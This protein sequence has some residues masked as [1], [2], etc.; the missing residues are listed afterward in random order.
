MK[1][2]NKTKSRNIKD[3]IKQ[4]P[5]IEVGGLSDDG[6]AFSLHRVM[7]VPIGEKVAW[8]RLECQLKSTVMA[9]PKE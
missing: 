7:A 1:K 2:Q 4:K 8:C 6:V 9:L 5:S 3:Q